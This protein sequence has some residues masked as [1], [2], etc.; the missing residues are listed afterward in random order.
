[1][2]VISIVTTT[3]QSQTLPT[4]MLYSYI[5]QQLRLCLQRLEL[6][7]RRRVRDFYNALYLSLFSVNGRVS[8]QCMEPL[9]SKVG[10]LNPML[11]KDGMAD[12]EK[13]MIHT[14]ILQQMVQVQGAK[15]ASPPH[16]T[17]QRPSSLLEEFF[18]E[19]KRADR[20]RDLEKE[21][22]LFIEEPSGGK[23]SRCLEFWTSVDAKRKYPC[24][25]MVAARYLPML[26]SSAASERVFSA[27]NLLVT[28]TRNRLS[29]AR[30]EQLVLLVANYHVYDTN[31]LPFATL[32]K[33][34]QR[35]QAEDDETSPSD[36]FDDEDE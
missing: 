26:A 14:W 32:D 19:V 2:E 21:L 22:K 20:G 4:L 15:G 11:D 29:A 30:M 25:S 36:D 3:M 18:P 17:E 7:D 5:A 1:M 24:L 23:P 9:V 34:L 16:A 10:Y 8:S 28:R 31:G 33:I 35:L 27:M 12:D 6:P 13:E